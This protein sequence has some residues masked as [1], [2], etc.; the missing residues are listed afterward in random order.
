M[1]STWPTTPRTRP[2]LC[3]L[4]VQMLHELG[5]EVPKFGSSTSETLSGF[6]A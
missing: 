3:T 6:S 1:A 4:W 5:V 2:P